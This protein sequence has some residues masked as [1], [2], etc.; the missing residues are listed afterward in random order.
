VT[1]SD[2]HVVDLAGGYCSDTDIPYNDE[3]EID[4]ADFLDRVWRI[5]ANESEAVQLADS[6]AA[7]CHVFPGRSLAQSMVDPGIL[8]DYIYYGGNCPL[9]WDNVWATG[10]RLDAEIDEGRRPSLDCGIPG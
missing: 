10:W 1:V 6:N 7:Y 5:T 2:I 8:S 4:Q 9:N 3:E